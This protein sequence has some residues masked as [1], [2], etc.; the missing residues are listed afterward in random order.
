MASPPTA[1]R[2]PEHSR[3]L[4]L[5]RSLPPNRVVLGSTG[6]WTGSHKS[7]HHPSRN[8]YSRRG[9]RRDPHPYAPRRLHPRTKETAQAHAS[10]VRLTAEREAERLQ[11]EAALL[12][13]RNTQLQQFATWLPPHSFNRLG[14]TL[15][16]DTKEPLGRRQRTHDGAS[17][18]PWSLGDDIVFMPGL[19]WLCPDFG[20]STRRFRA[21]TCLTWASCG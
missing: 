3:W 4:A 8:P 19:G 14:E 11:L 20:G 17:G 13:A 12:E 21:P 1:R 18:V 9:W 6:W 16:V 10:L 5:S 15:A 2:F 7:H